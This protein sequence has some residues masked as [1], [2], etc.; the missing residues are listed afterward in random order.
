MGDSDG[1]RRAQ[2]VPRG[3]S[4]KIARQL[5]QFGERSIQRGSVRLVA[6]ARERAESGKPPDGLAAREG[7]AQS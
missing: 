6:T 2:R 1:Q 5:N 4:S 7:S 3:R